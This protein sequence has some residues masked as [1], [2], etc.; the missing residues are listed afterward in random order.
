LPNLGLETLHHVHADDVAQAFEKALIHWSS[1]VGESFF[2][3]S[4]AALS[5]RGFAEAA[6]AWFGKQ[7][8][9]RF[10]PLEEWKATLPENFVDSALAHLSHSSNHSIAKAQRLLEYT[11]RYT[12]LE[13][14]REAV[15]WLIDHGQLQ[16]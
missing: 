7:V 9:L 1:V 5:L 16:I 2:I 10:L 13:A 3:V 15:F 4:P 12:S 8:N 14:V 6:A 11:P